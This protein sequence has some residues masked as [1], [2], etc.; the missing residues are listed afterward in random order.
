MSDSSKVKPFLLATASFMGGVAT[1][2]FLS[3]NKGVKNRKWLAGQLKDISEWAQM[4]REDILTKSNGDLHQLRHHIH[5]GIQQN[6][7]DAYEATEH[8]P[9]SD[10]DLLHG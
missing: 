9:L 10:K 5:D 2:I 7:P 4:R 8:I 3:P 1:G 6:V